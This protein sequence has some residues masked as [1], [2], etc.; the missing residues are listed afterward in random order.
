M[1]LSNTFVIIVCCLAIAGA[2]IF[3]P[4][5]QKGG[6]PQE[7][8]AVIEAQNIAGAIAWYEIVSSKQIP[9]SILTNSARLYTNLHHALGKQNIDFLGSNPRWEEAGRL[10]DSWHHEYVIEVVKHTNN[11]GQPAFQLL[12]WSRGDKRGPCG[13][14]NDLDKSP[15]D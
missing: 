15:Y 11:L 14:T 4:F 6:D 9:I 8:R 1:K 7:A 13:A 12:V 2:L 5:F 10:V 3:Y